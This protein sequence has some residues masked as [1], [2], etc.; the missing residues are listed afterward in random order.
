MSSAAVEATGADTHRP[1][2]LLVI[3][4]DPSLVALAGSLQAAAYEVLV[5]RSGAD[6]VNLVGGD[7]I[8]LVI[9]FAHAGG[10]EAAATLAANVRMRHAPLLFVA[11]TENCVDIEQAYKVGAVDVV[12]RSVDEAILRAKVSAFVELERGRAWERRQELARRE[13]EYASLQRQF[14]S[15]LGQEL[16]PPINVILGWIRMLRDGGMPEPQRARALHT[17]ERNA[18]AQLELIEEMLD[19]SRMSSETLTLHLATVDLVEVVRLAVEAVRPS[20]IEK[21]VTLFAALD[22]DVAPLSGDRERLRQIAHR[23]VS[24]AVLCTPTEGVVTVS[25]SNAETNVEL[26]IT[27][28]GSG[29][30]PALVPGPLERFASDALGNARAAGG[31]GGGLAIVHHLVD[32]H[33]GAIRVES[34]GPAGGCRFVV[35]LP[36]A[37]RPPRTDDEVR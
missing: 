12:A 25:L 13:A 34:V 32:L 26:A 7:R 20:A 35:T 33:D 15:T 1:K 11:A 31:L 8:A 17:M 36:V 30:E 21:Q 14:L 2:I 28:T 4:D 23:L 18:C 9:L 5:A 27:D 16:R 10:F 29:I 22:A 19:V 37:G 3:D 24:N 6:A